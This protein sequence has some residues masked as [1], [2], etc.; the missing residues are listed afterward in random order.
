M[1]ETHESLIK[2]IRSYEDRMLRKLTVFRRMA[3][4]SSIALLF[5]ITLGGWIRAISVIPLCPEWPSCF[6]RWIPPLSVSD[7]PANFQTGSFDFALAWME[8]V[9]RVSGIFIFL[10]I[11]YS[12]YY[13]IR[14]LHHYS[15][16]FFG[17][18]VT[19][20][21]MIAEVTAGSRML[22]LQAKPMLVSLHTGLAFVLFSL[23]LYLTYHGYLNSEPSLRV[24]IKKP[25]LLRRWLMSVWLLSIFQVIMGSEVRQHLNRLM[26]IF[27]HLSGHILIEKMT[28]TAYF[29]GWLGFIMAVFTVY[30]SYR[31]IRLNGSI[32][33][34]R[35]SAWSLALSNLLLLTDGILL[36]SMGIP[37]FAQALHLIF[38]AL[39]IGS[40][41]ILFL[42]LKP[43]LSG[44]LS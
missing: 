27:P 44:S 1:S 34:I 14:Y 18:V 4:A 21:L 28:G 22:Y 20:L 26:E 32:P 29:H 36:F 7:L 31:I 2:E 12:A 37:V 13:A 24:K 15:P 11:S 42:A 3:L 43:R 33:V 38:A 40:L 41:V 5:Q 30:V 16:L 25:V 19:L 10:F 35:N 23:L 9:L 6:G 8:F 17:S 39:F